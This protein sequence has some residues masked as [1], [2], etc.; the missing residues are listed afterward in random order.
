MSQRVVKSDF[1]AKVG[2]RL[3]V[4]RFERGFTIRKLAEVSECSAD[5]ILQ[6]ELGRTGITTTTLQRLA[7][8]LRVQPFDILNHDTQTD[9]VGWMVEMMR[10]DPESVQRVLGELRGKRG[11]VGARAGSSVPVG[12]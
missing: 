1:M 3:R 7:L 5:T 4:L 2:A 12:G 10:R 8:A 6:V 11:S 9:D